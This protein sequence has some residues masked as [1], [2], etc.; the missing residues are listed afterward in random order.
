[1]ALPTW[2]WWLWLAGFVVC[3]AYALFNARAGDTLSETAWRYVSGLKRQQDGTW[4][5][6][7]GVG[8]WRAFALFA[9]LVWLA[10][11]LAFG[12]FAG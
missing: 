3:E 11:H 4:R 9:F 10:F 8:S 1:M 12:W 2:V 5:P 6:S 7:K